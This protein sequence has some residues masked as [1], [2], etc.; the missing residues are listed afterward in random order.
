MPSKISLCAV[1]AAIFI[2]GDAMARSVNAAPPDDAC[3]LLTQAQVSV[4]RSES[5]SP[6]APGGLAFPER[7]GDW[8]RGRVLILAR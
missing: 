2:V 4:S 7:H 8:L 6:S 1:I 5:A 3:S